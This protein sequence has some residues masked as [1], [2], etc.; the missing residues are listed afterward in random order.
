MLGQ[1]IEADRRE[2]DRRIELNEVVA[3]SG[4]QERDRG[5]GQIS[6]RIEQRDAATGGEVLGNQIEE[7]GRFAGAGLPDDIEVARS[8]GRGEGHRRIDPVSKIEVVVNI[9][10]AHG[11]RR[12]TASLDRP[13]LVAVLWRM[14]V[15]DMIQRATESG[16][17]IDAC[18]SS[19]FVHPFHPLTEAR[20]DACAS[21]VVL[22]YQTA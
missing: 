16:E 11:P 17:V 20:L 22:F 12:A 18:R 14:S 1:E 6:V 3:A 5:F 21:G 4:R 7:Q 9:K 8:R 15:G 10:S 19:N 2:R 13:N